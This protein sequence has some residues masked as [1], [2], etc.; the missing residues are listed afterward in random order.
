[1]KKILQKIFIGDYQAEL[2]EPQNAFL[3]QIDIIK[4]VWK[5]ENYYAFGVERVFRLLLAV[6]QLFMP[7]MLV[8][9]TFGALG[10]LS[11]KL[12]VEAYVLLKAIFPIL[13]LKFNFFQYRICVFIC[14]IFIIETVFYLLYLVF[15]SDQISNQGSYKRSL[16]FLFLN[17]I[18]I[19]LCF[20]AIYAYLNH[21]NYFSTVKPFASK[22]AIIYYSFVTAASI[23]YG[24]YSPN[25]NIGQILVIFQS[26]IFF[27]Y[28]AI[29]LNFF[30]SR[31]QV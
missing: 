13:L 25:T 23:G 9:V 30:H 1:M 17:Y 22:T 21:Y 20:A 29:I 31:S 5:N 3:R 19:A 2:F 28:L 18:E 6:V 24:D 4:S 12:A 15:L 26:L 27:L 14:V 8:K 11:K 7:V 10:F 16:L